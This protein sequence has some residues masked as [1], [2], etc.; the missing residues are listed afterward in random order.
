[1]EEE[2]NWGMGEII[3]EWRRGAEAKGTKAQTKN[4]IVKGGRQNG[5]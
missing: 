4:R 2:W 5:E 1:V 3:S